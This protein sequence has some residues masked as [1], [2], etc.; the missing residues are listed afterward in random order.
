MYV[1]K[2]IPTLTGEAAERFVEQ[3]ELVDSGKA[4]KKD[5][6][7]AQRAYDKIMER[8]SKILNQG[9]GYMPPSIFCSRFPD[10]YTI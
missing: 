7:A 8:S 3:M 4:P 9:W 2:P 6:S 10:E 5:I 1:A